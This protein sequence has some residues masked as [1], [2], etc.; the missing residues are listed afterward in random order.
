MTSRASSIQILQQ[1]LDIFWLSLCF[2]GDF[3]VGSVVDKTSEIVLLCRGLRVGA[4][5]DTLYSPV[6][7]EGDSLSGHCEG[8]M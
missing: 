1:I 4:E 5:E 7:E 3:A 2:A 8:R 6:D